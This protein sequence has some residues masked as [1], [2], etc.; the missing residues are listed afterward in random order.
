VSA[1]KKILVVD[2]ERGVRHLLWD[3]LSGEGF[4]VSMAEDGEDSLS[5]LG[6]T[7]FDLVITDIH[8]PRL[9]GIELLKRMKKNSRKEKVIIMTGDV[10]DRRLSDPNLPTVVSQLEKPVSIARL[11]QEVGAAMAGRTGHEKNVR[12]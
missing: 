5:Q 9:D 10:S 2:D 12:A 6:H 7:R 8:M 11:L 1:S 4:E 3:V